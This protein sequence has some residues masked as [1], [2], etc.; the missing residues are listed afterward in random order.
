MLRRMD[1]LAAVVFTSISLCRGVCGYRGLL[2]TLRCQSC[3]ACPSGAFCRILTESRN[4]SPCSFQ[5]VLF[6]SV[7]SGKRVTPLPGGAGQDCRG[8]PGAD[9]A[10]RANLKKG[11]SAGHL[12]KAAGYLGREKI[13][14]PL[15]A[16]P[17]GKFVKKRGAFP[18]VRESVF[19]WCGMLGTKKS[20]QGVTTHESL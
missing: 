4:V 19:P 7:L 11:R 1:E 3:F 9:G 5:K 10:V 17:A 13:A 12:P 14:G 15:H 16:G 8:L 18:L 20:P 2:S 6:F